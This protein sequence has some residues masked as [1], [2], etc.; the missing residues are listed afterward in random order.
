MGLLN[1]RTVAVPVAALGVIVG[2]SAFSAGV[3]SAHRAAPQAVTRWTRI[4]AT[5]LATQSAGLYRTSDGRLHVVW[6]R[7]DGGNSF[8]LHY[9]TIGA[10]E[11]LINTG[12]IFSKWPS[13]GFYPRL[14]AGPGGGIRL[15][16]PGANGQSGSPYNNDSMYSATSS[17]AGTSW[18]LTAGSLS[19]SKL[20]TLTDDAAVTETNGTPIAAWS[21]VTAL[22]YHIGVD[23]SSPAAAPDSSVSA[24]SGSAL[25]GPTLVRDKNG[26]I[27]A[28][29]FN[30]SLAASQGYWV[31][32]IVPSAA[33][34]KAPSSGGKTAA[35]NHPLQAVA[36]AARVGGGEY[37]AYCVPST[38]TRCTHVALW[39]VGAAKAV[40][41]PG[42]STKTAAHVAIAAGP[43][44][45]LW[46]AWYDTAANKIRVV[47][48]NA[49]ATKFGSVRTLGVP[50]KVFTVS[51]L[52]AQG[53]AGPL[54]IV[55]LVTQSGTGFP[56]SY[57]D[58]QV[59]P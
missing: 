10:A 48:T 1:R 55:A 6:T 36:L 23:P 9:S 28:A 18:V 13:L 31:E 26:S 14:V 22:T 56:M 12:T 39:K 47:E 49:A 52:Q 17:K 33:R 35:N 2:T 30:E 40:T 11:K 51:D 42:S 43:G 24:G 38:T 4:S 21:T 37:L 34:V 25:V 58:T 29:W 7:Q 53:S 46:I 44:G 19:Q 57:W 15:I 59:K 50:P 3:P 41:V 20:V 45:H 8:S 54:D 16:F 5:K 27:W 32:R